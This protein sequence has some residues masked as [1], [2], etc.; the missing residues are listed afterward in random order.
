MDAKPLA[1]KPIL[2]NTEGLRHVLKDGTAYAIFFIDARG[3][4]VAWSTSAERLFL[5][6]SHEILGKHFSRLFFRTEE[7][8]RG[9]QEQELRT[10]EAAGRAYSDRWY[11]RKDGT[12]LWCCG[13]TAPLMTGHECGP[14]FVKVACDFTE[15]KRA[16]PSAAAPSSLAA[17]FDRILA[18]AG[19][20]HSPHGQYSSPSRR[21]AEV[22]QL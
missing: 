6:P 19:C 22:V 2:V 7:V 15:K 18:M 20:G 10:A 5:Y 17:E 11:V 8:Y 14:F 16:N 3:S 13:L 1:L 4:V 12:A 9:E 21:A